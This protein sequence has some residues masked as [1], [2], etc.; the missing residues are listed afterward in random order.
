MPKASDAM[1][2]VLQLEWTIQVCRGQREHIKK[3]TV[4]TETDFLMVL[5]IKLEAVE[6]DVVWV[7]PGG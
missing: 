4:V 6:T 2:V 1:D 3:D 7:S 5:V